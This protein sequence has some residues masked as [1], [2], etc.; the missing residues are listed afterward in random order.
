MRDAVY[1]GDRYRPPSRLLRTA[2]AV[3]AWLEPRIPARLRA[4][5]LRFVLDHI[6]HEQSTTGYIDIGP[7]NKA[8]NVIAVWSA[9]PLSE[10][11]RRSLEALPA[12][13]FDCER[14][15]TMQTYNSS[16]TWDTSFVAMCLA[17]SGRTKTFARMAAAAHRF[18]D[19][20]Q[21]QEDVDQRQRYFRDSTKGGWTFSNREQG[22]PV[23]DCT[24]FGL[25]A[26]LALAP[27]AD[28][29]MASARLLD[30]V[31]L[32]LFWQNR[33]GGWGTY[34]KQRGP[35]WL[36][37][38]N[39]SEVFGDIM[40]DMSQVELTSSA[41]QALAA[42]RSHL[43]GCGEEPRAAK[44]TAAIA[45][46]ERFLR[47]LQRADGS[48]EGNWGICFTYGTWFGISGLRAAGARPGDPAIEGAATFLAAKQCSDGGWGESHE[49]CIRR[50]YI[51]HPDGGQLVMTAWALLGLLNGG[52]A[53]I[54]RS[55][56]ARASLSD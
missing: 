42:A 47:S 27:V 3:L 1:L 15:K 56:R 9:D 31:D 34:E 37:A 4:H 16:Q 6:M 39:G 33:D 25:M 23:V 19:R 43:D 30:A 38:L 36:E 12:Y 20:N 55:D 2:N 24:A 53:A 11:T 48:W 14:G 54:P 18:I 32:L 44:I 10:H 28:E 51:Q 52:F 8:L 22:W 7:V 49:S 46:G 26:A 45:R 40:V 13:L 50:R 35:A 17:E 21:I 5:A 29:P 41:I